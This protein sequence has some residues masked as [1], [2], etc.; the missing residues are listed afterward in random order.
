MPS[1]LTLSK[2]AAQN[3]IEAF[4]IKM[5]EVTEPPPAYVL[6]SS[7]VGQGRMEILDLIGSALSETPA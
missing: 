6:S 2:K 1:P 4:L 3:N 5:R 7:K